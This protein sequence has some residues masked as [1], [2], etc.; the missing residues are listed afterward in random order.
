MK[1][2]ILSCLV[3]VPALALAQY[4]LRG[5]VR[6]GAD[7]TPLPFATVFLANTT[8][9]TTTDD[10]G[11]FTL[12]NLPVGEYEL[13]AS[14]V[15]FRTLKVPV[16]T[17]ETRPFRLSLKPDET[18][19]SE[20]T[21]RA[22]ARRGPDWER[23]LELF[24]NY[25]IGRSENAA[26]CRLLNPEALYFPEGDTAVLVARA[27]E[28]LRIENRAL[29]YLIRFELEHYTYDPHTQRV[30][31]EGEVLF[32]NLVG[33]EAEQARWLT[34]RRVAYRG[35]L[36]HFMRA[37]YHNRLTEENFF[38]QK[39]REQERRDGSTK[40]IAL[41]PDT[42]V[43]RPALNRKHDVWYPTVHRR[44]LLDTLRSTPERPV[45]AFDGLLVVTYAGEAE[46]FAYIRA[47]R[48]YDPG[49]GTPPQRSTVRLVKPSVQVGANGQFFDPYGLVAEGY[50][51]WE[52]IAGELPFDY[53]PNRDTL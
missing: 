36:M 30:R 13:V 23:K 5:Q 40:L 20:V 47:H 32:E 19:L 14:Y 34:N 10:Q 52:L 2:L 9:G 38:V 31:Y 4:T 3:L 27:A 43:R 1:Y 16:R 49:P 11:R 33:T 25:F 35:S 26:A 22:R 24:K 46:P 29:G 51:S 44:R 37:L 18:R 53:D 39:V 8:K 42:T 21:V 50:W 17:D 15:G 41:L 28:P 45:V 12:R 6:N 48:N 7:D